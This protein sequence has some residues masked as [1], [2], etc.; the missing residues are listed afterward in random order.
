MLEAMQGVL[1]ID[2]PTN[3]TSFDVV[4]KV[5]RIVESSGLNTTGRK[6]FPVGHTGT[7][8][9]LATGLLVLLLGN[10]TK[11]APELTKLDKIYDATMRLGQTSSTGDEE[12][13]KTTVSALQ[14]TRDDVAAALRHFLGDSQQ[15]PPIYSA[16]KV[17]GQRAYKLAREGKT[18]EL[19]PR[20]VHIESIELTSYTYPDATFTVHVSSGTYI[21]SLIEDVGTRLGTGAYM[22]ALRRTHVGP[23]RLADALSV[24]DLTPEALQS[25]ASNL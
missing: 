1:L 21:R 23:F 9:P 20:P 7:L 13:E 25:H 19:K 17:N 22:H 14:P 6:R 15:I 10:Y 8:D 2:K 12:G 11:R 24:A 3:W 18:A 5:R 4:H 16:V